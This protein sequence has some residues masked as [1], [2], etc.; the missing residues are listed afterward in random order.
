MGCNT[1]GIRKRPAY[2]NPYAG[3][4]LL[5]WKRKKDLPAAGAAVRQEARIF[6]LLWRCGG[7]GGLRFFPQTD[8][9]QILHMSSILHG[10]CGGLIQLSEEDVRI[11]LPCQQLVSGDVKVG[12]YD[13]EQING[14]AF[15][16]AFNVV[17]MLMAD[18]QNVRKLGLRESGN[19]PE[20]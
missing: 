4:S 20:F 1:S 14:R 7:T 18:I 13:H 19:F 11:F 6:L 10:F 12:G 2:R 5:A 3:L 15:S 8:G 16:S 17:Q 9:Q